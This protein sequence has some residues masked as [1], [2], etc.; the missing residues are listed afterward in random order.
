MKKIYLSP[1]T[2][3]QSVYLVNGIAQMNAGS[4][5]GGGGTGGSIGEGGIDIN[6]KERDY[7]EE[8]E[9]TYGNIW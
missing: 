6:A 3:D 7:F 5:N 8:K 9:I 4:G 1:I 2:Y